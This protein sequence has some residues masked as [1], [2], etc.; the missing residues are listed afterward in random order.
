MTTVRVPIHLGV[1]SLVV[2]LALGQQNLSLPKQS[3][4]EILTR[5]VTM[6]AAPETVRSAFAH[7]L[8]AANVAGGI[9]TISSCQQDQEHDFRGA[10]TS[11]G[12][13][14][15]TIVASEPENKWVMSRGVVNLVPAGDLPLLL[16]VPISYFKVQNARTVLEAVDQLMALPEVQDRIAQLH[17]EELNRHVGLSDL[18]RPGS[19][20]A[21]RPPLNL[22]LRDV[23][24]RDALNAIASAHGSAVW[25]YTE[26][27]CRSRDQFSIDFLVR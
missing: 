24:L 21:D 7:A 26:R 16:D 11:L 2:T 25:A 9:A 12:N 20:S 3:R 15:D 10:T 4:D 13:A 14:L 6:P 8:I 27:H 17:L 1:I 23:N 5:Q 18:K 22:N 19:A